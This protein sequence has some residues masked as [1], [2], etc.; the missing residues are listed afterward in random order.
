MKKT[1]H[2]EG[3]WIWWLEQIKAARPGV[4]LDYEALLKL[5]ITGTKWEDAL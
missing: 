4:E 2:T 1:T 5:Y 3:G